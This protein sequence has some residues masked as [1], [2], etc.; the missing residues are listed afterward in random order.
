MMSVFK[1]FFVLGMGFSGEVIIVKDNSKDF[2]LIE[3]DGNEY[4][5]KYRKNLPDGMEN[6]CNKAIVGDKIFLQNGCN[7]TVC[8]NTELE[9]LSRMDHEGYLIDCIGDKLFYGQGTVDNQD[10]KIVIE[11]LYQDKESAPDELSLEKLQMEKQVTLQPP[12]PYGWELWLSICCVNE[13]YAV[14][15]TNSL[16]MDMF[17]ARGIIYMHYSTD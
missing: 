16:S 8:Y 1:A 14:V 12:V 6:H 4:T 9:E 7:D 5:Q 10:W 3:Y 15:E 11:Q 13:S 2:Y 17:D